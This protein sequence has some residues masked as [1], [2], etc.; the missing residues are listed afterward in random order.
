MAQEIPRPT[1]FSRS[2]RSYHHA[3]PGQTEIDFLS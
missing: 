1:L 2:E 3:Q